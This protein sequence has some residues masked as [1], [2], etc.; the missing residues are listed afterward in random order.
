MEIWT[1]ISIINAVII[2]GVNET[3]LI[4][5]V[6]GGLGSLIWRANVGGSSPVVLDASFEG[7]FARNTWHHICL[8]IPGRR[9]TCSLYWNG[10][11]AASRFGI[12]SRGTLYT[13]ERW[14]PRPPPQSAGTNAAHFGDMRQYYVALTAA[15][16]RQ[17]Y[18]ASASNYGRPLIG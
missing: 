14:A 6:D 13:G 7:G 8:V 2:I 11:L 9:G 10:V 3:P 5:V 1:T 18:N 12:F 15:E 17:N 4:S 16:V